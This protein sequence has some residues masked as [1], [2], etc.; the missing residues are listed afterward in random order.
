LIDTSNFDLKAYL[1]KQAEVVNQALESYLPAH[2]SYIG[3]LGEVMRYSLFPG[4]K[5]F[6][7]ILTLAVAEALGLDPKL[8]LPAACSFE[9]VHCFSLV[10]D[11]LPCMDMMI[12][13]AANLLCT[14]LM[15]KTP[16]CWPE[17]L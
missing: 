17:T 3:N 14:K 10:H 6:R 2:A 8:A 7:P 1:K 13:A 15:A 4:G 9:L 16:L 12:C 5:R 11:D